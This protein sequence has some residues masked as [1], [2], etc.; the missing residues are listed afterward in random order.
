MIIP[1]RC[2][3]LISI[4]TASILA[5]DE[6]S[7]LS[8]ELERLE[9]IV[10]QPNGRFIELGDD[11][12]IAHE[13]IEAV[14]LKEG[15]VIIFLESGLSVKL[16]VTNSAITPSGVRESI[17]DY[18]GSDGRRYKKV[19]VDFSKRLRDYIAGQKGP[20]PNMNLTV[21]R[22]MYN[23]T[24]SWKYLMLNCSISHSSQ[25]DSE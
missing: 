21:A 9:E 6:L 16:D 2:C 5:A 1:F 24:L 23:R 18:I 8:G 11:L 17:L 10:E 12:S 4:L 22:L 14:S 20:G 7:V 25:L 3:V 13:N 19:S 15:Q